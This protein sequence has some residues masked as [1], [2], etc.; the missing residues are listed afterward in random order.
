MSWRKVAAIARGIAEDA[1]IL[2]GICSVSYG[3]WMFWQPGGY[4]VAG[5]L[6]MTLGILLGRVERRAEKV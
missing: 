4:I 6:S 1:L 3:F 2:G 5:V